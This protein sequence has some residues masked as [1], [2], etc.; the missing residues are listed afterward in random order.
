[1]LAG[2]KKRI[3]TILMSLEDLPRYPFTI[4][5][6]CER[7]EAHCD[8]DCRKASKDAW[9]SYAGHVCE[10]WDLDTEIGLDINKWFVAMKDH[11][12]EQEMDCDSY[13]RRHN[14]FPEAQQLL[15]LLRKSSKVSW[16]WW[17]DEELI[18]NTTCVLFE[19]LSVRAGV[20]FTEHT[21]DPVDPRSLL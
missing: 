19:C 12:D 9:E 8:V 2:A 16:K 7:C 20:C 10:K 11:L 15:L 4:P 14:M 6:A 13:L 5:G 21:V 17:P 18:E 3:E 1:M